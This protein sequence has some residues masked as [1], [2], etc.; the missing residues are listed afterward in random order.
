MIEKHFTVDNTL[1]GPDHAY[2]ILPDEL[3][4]M[5]RAVRETEQAL[6]SAEK[7]VRDEERELREYAHRA[8]Q[9][10]REIKKGEVLME[11]ENIEIL[12]PGR[13]KAGLHPRFM[14][15]IVGK[16]ARRD[17]PLGDGVQEVDYE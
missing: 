7:V 1:P 11:G 15:D 5:V 16:R 4:A 12:R 17:I 14:M 13:Q 3:K 2:S 6:G 8:I 9:A 10:T